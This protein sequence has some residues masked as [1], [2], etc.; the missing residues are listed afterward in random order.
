MQAEMLM[1]SQ[2]PL[3]VAENS[4]RKGNFLLNPCSHASQVSH[5]TSEQQLRQA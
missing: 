3:I 2:R 4:K 1:T 5:S